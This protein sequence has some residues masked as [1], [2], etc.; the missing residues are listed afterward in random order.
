MFS[1]NQNC[2][3]LEHPTPFFDTF[4][5]SKINIKPIHYVRA[6]IVSKKLWD[7]VNAFE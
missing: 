3:K 5:C 1:T 6:S 7:I 2:P 4:Q